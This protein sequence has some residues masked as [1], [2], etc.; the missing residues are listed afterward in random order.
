MDTL[1]FRGV[2]VRLSIGQ[3]KV[4]SPLG[5][6]NTAYAD[7]EFADNNGRVWRWRWHSRAVLVEEFFYIALAEM[8]RAMDASNTYSGFCEVMCGRMVSSK[9]MSVYHEKTLQA[10]RAARKVWSEDLSELRYW[11]AQK[12]YQMKRERRG[13][14]GY[15][16]FRR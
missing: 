13:M 1:A 8:F 9:P 3:R 10:S 11:C 15:T 2:E 16:P 14:M 4:K 5:P 7:V 12:A 6:G